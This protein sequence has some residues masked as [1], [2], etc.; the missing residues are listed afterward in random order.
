M[1]SVTRRGPSSRPTWP[2]K[3]EML[4]VQ[5]TIIA[6]FSTLSFGWRGTVVL[7]GHC[8]LAL[9]NTIRCVN[10]A[11]AGPRKAS[12]RACSRPCKR[13][14]WIGCYSIPPSCGPTPRRPAAEKKP[15]R[16]RSPRPQPRR[17]EHQ[18]AR[19]GRRARSAGAGGAG[20]RSAARLYAG[21][22]VAGD[23]AAYTQGA[24]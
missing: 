20:A 2:A 13:P 10:V 7:G 14:T 23:R 17:A 5:A 16:R 12:G 6:S 19:A 9:A 15:M 3:Q 11:D 24:G 18:A 21:R 4:V 1:N 8:R 22:G